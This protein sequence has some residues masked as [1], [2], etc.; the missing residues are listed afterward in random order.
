MFGWNALALM[1]TARGTYNSKCNDIAQRKFLII[2]FSACITVSPLV[3]TRSQSH[4]PNLRISFNLCS[5]QL[6]SIS[7]SKESTD[8]GALA[9]L[10]TTH[11]LPVPQLQSLLHAVADC[12]HAYC[13][14]VSSCCRIVS[15]CCNCLISALLP[16]CT[17]PWYGQCRVLGGRGLKS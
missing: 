11:F 1:L 9:L 4:R 3:V 17:R 8:M 13:G 2:L 5:A 15:Y 16:R 7:T 12:V 6:L 10:S 14:I